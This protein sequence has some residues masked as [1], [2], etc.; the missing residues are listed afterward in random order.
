[1]PNWVTKT[2]QQYPWAEYC[3]DCQGFVICATPCLNRGHTVITSVRHLDMIIKRIKK[4]G[5]QCLQNQK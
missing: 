2:F 1:M 4:E 3:L 5:G